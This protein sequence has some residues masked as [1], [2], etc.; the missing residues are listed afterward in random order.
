MINND[1]STYSDFVYWMIAVH[2]LSDKCS[3]PRT[4]LSFFT[5]GV[6]NDIGKVMTLSYATIDAALNSVE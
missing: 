2:L 6:S 3:C 5:L 4:K 1:I